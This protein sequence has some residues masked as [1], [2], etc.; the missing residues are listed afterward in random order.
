MTTYSQHYP[1][2]F[3]LHLRRGDLLKAVIGQSAYQFARGLIMPNTVPPILNAAFVDNYFVEIR[4][5]LRNLRLPNFKPLF[6]IKL[7]H[8]TTPETIREA[9][10]VGAVAGKVYPIGVTTN[11]DDGVSDFES[12]APVFAAMEKWGMVLCLHGEKPGEFCLDREVEFLPTLDCLAKNFPKLRIVLEHI[13]TAKAVERVQ[14][15]P[16]TVAATITAHHLLLTLDDV[17]GGKL[18]P[19]NFCLPIAKRPK[20]RAAVRMAAISGNP[21]FFFGSDSAPHLKGDKECAEGCAGCYTAPVAMPLLVQIFERMNALDKLENF[22]SKFGADFY[23]LPLNEGTLVL[24]KRPWT[25]PKEING[26]VPFLAG[27]TMEWS[28]ACE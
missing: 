18:R 28:F 27:E 21:K 13:S 23:H 15:L 26:V 12:M 3:H 1:D 10:N 8:R 20:D 25:V 24:E 19:H 4:L 16:N 5:A 22:T 14:S 9:I 11:S 7:N 2:D 17:I 6:A